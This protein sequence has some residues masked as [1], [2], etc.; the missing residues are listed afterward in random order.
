MEV[1]EDQHKCFISV[2]RV[3]VSL[4]QQKG[5]EVVFFRVFHLRELLQFH[6]TLLHLRFRLGLR[7]QSFAKPPWWNQCYTWCRM[8]LFATMT[9]LLCQMAL[10]S[11]IE[12]CLVFD[13]WLLQRLCHMDWTLIRRACVSSTAASKSVPGSVEPAAGGPVNAAFLDSL[14]RH[15]FCWVRSQG[16]WHFIWTNYIKILIF[17]QPIPL[18]PRKKPRETK[19]DLAKWNNISPT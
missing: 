14:R 11:T 10:P 16:D 17:H 13:I 5:M 19:H 4:L 15:H 9:A 6:L 8:T 18:G 1:P 3:P 7:R 12:A 2:L